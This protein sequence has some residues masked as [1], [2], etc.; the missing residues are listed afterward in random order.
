MWGKRLEI[1]LEVRGS[2]Q[3]L[4]VLAQPGEPASA[5]QLPHIQKAAE[6]LGK[7]VLVLEVNSAEEF[8]RAFARLT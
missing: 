5:A 1:L 4:G 7:E 2:V 6:A 3:R 8:A